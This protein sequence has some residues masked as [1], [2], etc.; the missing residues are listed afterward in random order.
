[1]VVL[2]E[3]GCGADTENLHLCIY[4]TIH[5]VSELLLSLTVQ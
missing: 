2:D 3:L 1:M 4:G 5:C